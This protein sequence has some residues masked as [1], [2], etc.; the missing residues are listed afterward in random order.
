LKCLLYWNKTRVIV[1][2]VEKT[3]FMG[4]K[5]IVLFFINLNYKEIEIGENMD[6]FNL[7][8][9]KFSSNIS[10]KWDYVTKCIL[11]IVQHLGINNNLC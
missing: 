1:L 4:S 9:N 6:W 5:C 3:H 2:N 11:G 8:E 7:N 10:K